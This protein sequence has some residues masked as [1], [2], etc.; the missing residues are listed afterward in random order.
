MLVLLL[1]KQ[2][3]VYSEIKNNLQF[4]ILCDYAFPINA[5]LYFRNKRRQTSN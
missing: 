5:I 2:D 1:E 3:F 4:F